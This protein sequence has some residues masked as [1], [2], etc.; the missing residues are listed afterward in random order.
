MI[1]DKQHTY[2]LLV[3][4]YHIENDSKFSRDIWSMNT[5]IELRAWLNDVWFFLQTWGGIVVLNDFST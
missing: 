1:T 2:K 5:F 4:K 3:T